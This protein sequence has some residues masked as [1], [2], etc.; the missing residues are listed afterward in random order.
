MDFRTTIT[1]LIE[2]L[3]GIEKIWFVPAKWKKIINSACEVL[4]VVL[5]IV[6]ENVQAYDFVMSLGKRKE[7]GLVAKEIIEKVNDTL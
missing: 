4:L 3:K 2:A 1:K 7:V 6:P 5:A